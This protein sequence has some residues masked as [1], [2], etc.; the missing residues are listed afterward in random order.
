MPGRRQAGYALHMP[1]AFGPLLREWRQVRQMSQLRLAEAAEVSTRH[2]S[3]IE[4]GRAAPSREMVLIL[5]SALDLPLRE[6]N[7]LLGAA[8]FAAV[9]RETDL[10]APEMSGVAHALGFLLDRHEPYGASVLDGSWNILRVNRGGLRMLGWLLEQPPPAEVAANAMR[11][12]FHPRGLRPFILN[13]EDLAAAMIERLHRE[14]S[15]GAAR[16]LLDEILSYPDVPHRFARPRLGEVPE[17]VLTLHL[18]KGERDL[19]LFTTLTTLGTPLDVTAQELR[20]ESYFPAD[21]ATEEWVRSLA[22]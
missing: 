11:I 6:R 16:A 17:V 2:I 5:A 8:G 20:I 19:R 3:F 1:A 15:H 21:E 10:R 22:S 14:V 18:R 9:Y 7:T 4:T 12:L 13:W